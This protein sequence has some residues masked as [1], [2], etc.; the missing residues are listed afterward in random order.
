MTGGG[1]A[2]AGGIELGS[3]ASFHRPAPAREPC[4]L[5]IAGDRRNR[6][7][8]E[9][10]VACAG[11]RVS[12]AIDWADAAAALTGEGP[13][14]W[15]VLEIEGAAPLP[16][17][18][19]LPRIDAWARKADAHVVVALDE[20]QIDLVA[21]VMLGR[22]QLLS[23]P[24]LADRVAALAIARGGARL[25]DRS[26]ESDG[27]RLLRLNQEVARIAETLARL[28]AG[29]GERAAAP[30]LDQS[31]GDRRRD[32]RGAA[33]TVAARD[34]RDAIRARRLRDR[35]FASGL[36]EDPAWDML[37]DLFAAELEGSAVS[38]SSL[39]IAAAVA[40]TTALRWIARLTDAGLLERRPDPFDK[41]RVF[42]ALSEAARQGMRGYCRAVR[43]A[44]LAI[45]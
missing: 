8:G 27:D 32:Y 17:E 44:G 6:L 13:I 19:A 22:A 20:A 11:G 18:A 35:F 28:A 16:L 40:P 41:R 33:P 29:E 25:R 9:E 12:A 45:A 23:A 38:V 1:A 37:L 4:A 39:C 5:V 10:A 3:A 43:E 42:M 2:R 21:A 15:L 26:N 31:V 7:C 34:V 14:D 30:P 36:F 24:T